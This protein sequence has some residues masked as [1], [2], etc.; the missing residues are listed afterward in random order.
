MSSAQR[1]GRGRRRSRSRYLALQAVYQWQLTGQETPVIEAQFLAGEGMDKADVGYFQ[2]LLRQTLAEAESLAACF[3]PY[4][5]RPDAQ[6]D[7]V[8]RAILLLGTYELA[9][10]PDIPYRVVVN[11]A[12]ELAKRFGAEQGHRFVNGVLDKVARQLRVREVQQARGE[13]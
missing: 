12:V 7:P 10:R 5:D 13:G 6:L 2:E 8:E 11:E 1:S 4:L 3:G 9:H